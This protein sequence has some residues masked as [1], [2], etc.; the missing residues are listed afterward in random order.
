MPLRQLAELE[1]GVGNL[2]AARSCAEESLAVGRLFDDRSRVGL[3]LES[4][5][6]IERSFGRHEQAREHL[7]EAVQIAR[8]SG[9]WRNAASLLIRLAASAG[10]AGTFDVAR[11]F[12]RES[13]DLVESFDGSRDILDYLEDRPR[14]LEA[15]TVLATA[16]AHAEAGVQLAG[17]VDAMRRTRQVPLPPTERAA[18][19]RALAEVR[20]ALGDD[21]FTRAWPAGQ[22]MSWEAAN[23]LATSLVRSTEI[24]RLQNP[25]P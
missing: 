15:A 22:A 13:L 5:S 6:S 20:R 10:E 8:A 3:A 11:S 7:E 23:E 14:W 24:S 16:T 25:L 4:L 17:A 21:A 2:E 18:R 19:D 1:Q 9:D 12:L